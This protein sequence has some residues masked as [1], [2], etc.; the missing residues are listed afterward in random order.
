MSVIGDREAKKL[1]KLMAKEA[2]V[3]EQNI[4]HALK[5][6]KKAEKAVKKSVK[7]VEKA[8]KQ[9]AKAMKQ[10][11]STAKGLIKA[12]HKHAD[13]LEKEAKIEERLAETRD[14]EASTDRSVQQL[15]ADLDNLQVSITGNAKERD[16]RLAEV[17]AHCGQAEGAPTSA[18]L[19]HL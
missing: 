18:Q 11:H 4:K 17:Y 13:V 12:K 14:K 9:K 10:E 7:A 5:D 1:E 6:V 15:H 2:K 16:T 3:E 19:A 8:E